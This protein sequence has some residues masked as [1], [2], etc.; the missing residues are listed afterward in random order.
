[1]SVKLYMEK[2]PMPMLWISVIASLVWSAGSLIAARRILSG[3]P[4]RPLPQDRVLIIVAILSLGLAPWISLVAYI[5]DDGKSV[6]G[7]SVN[8][9]VAAVLF[10]TSLRAR[11]RSVQRADTALSDTPFWQ[12][13]AV[14]MALTLTLTYVAYFIMTWNNP[15]L[16]VPLFLGSALFVIVVATAGHIVLTLFHAPITDVQESD[17][18]DREAER[19]GVRNAYVVLAWGIWIVPAVCILKQPLWIIANVAFAF[20]VLAE[21]VKY[22]SQV[23]YYRTGRS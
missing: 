3:H 5:A 10:L 12:K 14:L 23:R 20:A 16:A 11:K 1:M 7:G 18:R 17:E 6:L 9:V 2:V 22:L 13:S 15:A 8:V 21:I 19:Y 4:E